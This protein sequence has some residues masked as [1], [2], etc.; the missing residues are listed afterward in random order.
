MFASMTT[1]TMALDG[2]TSSVGWAYVLCQL[3]LLQS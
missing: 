3:V 1:N 2:H